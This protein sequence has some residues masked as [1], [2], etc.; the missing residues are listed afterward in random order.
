[1]EEL[2]YAQ[3]GLDDY[4]RTTTG[5]F[6]LAD[7]GQLELVVDTREMVVSSLGQK[8]PR[9]KELK[10]NRSFVPS[11]RD[12]GSA[13][14]NLQVLWLSRCRLED[15]SGL[16]ALPALKELYVSFNDIT[17]AT[18]V[19][20]LEEI[21]T[22]DLEGNKIEGVDGVQLL[23]LCPKLANLNLASN[24][25]AFGLQYRRRVCQHLPR[26][27]FL[28]DEPV[29]AADRRPPTLDGFEAAAA[30]GDGDEEM[31]L[32]EEERARA[33]AELNLISSGIKYARVGIDSDEFELEVEDFNPRIL[34]DSRPTTAL[35]NSRPGSALRGP[36]GG[37]A[38][39]GGGRP[40]PGSRPG[41]ALAAAGGR[42]APRP[43]SA[44]TGMGA[45]PRPP[46]PAGE[47]LR[48]DG[49]RPSTSGGERPFSAARKSSS[50][51]QGL[52]WRKNKQAARGVDLEA[53]SSL[54]LLEDNHLA[55][56]AAL[57]LLRG[58]RRV[59][60]ADSPGTSAK[61]K[62]KVDER[63]LGGLG[64]ADLEEDGLLEEL[65]KW[66]LETAHVASTSCEVPA[67]ELLTSQVSY[68]AASGGNAEVLSL[69]APPGLSPFGGEDPLEFG[70]AA[71]EPRRSGHLLESN[72][73][74]AVYNPKPPLP[75]ASSAG[76]A[77]ENFSTGFAE[78]VEAYQVR[79]PVKKGRKI[80]GIPQ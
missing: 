12:L 42:T 13:L 59:F 10:L 32:L 16:H 45:R 35:P 34:S 71:A 1:M 76:S 74:A 61:G 25:L 15:L 19:A 77:D 21:E 27:E 26:L 3:E 75:R 64:A 55:G 79:K 52:Y 20:D 49:N 6:D 65:K 53:S 66:K 67:P 43:G 36:P 4:L 60:S 41:T 56:T 47:W 72:V 44:F 51:G 5:C 7:V 37:D 78:R 30:A 18:P 14:R 38:Y 48:S 50:A 58:D 46:A 9:L 68:S 69:D 2:V 8:L 63:R 70:P 11:V 22:V 29:S 17:D 28:D 23:E 73:E 62:E 33:E 24:P 31:R 54:T 57:A 80:V 40:A 39:G